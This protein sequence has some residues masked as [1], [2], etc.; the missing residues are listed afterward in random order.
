MSNAGCEPFIR[1]K[2]RQTREK[3]QGNGDKKGV[4]VRG[5]QTKVSPA[6]RQ[7]NGQACLPFATH[8]NSKVVSLRDS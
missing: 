4:I 3:A 1:Y 5:I 2:V 7:W 8:S 6:S